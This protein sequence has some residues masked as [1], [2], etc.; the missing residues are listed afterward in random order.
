MFKHLKHYSNGSI[1]NEKFLTFISQYKSIKGQTRKYF[2]IMLDNLD[3]L[4]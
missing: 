1:K 2:L 4:T 3:I